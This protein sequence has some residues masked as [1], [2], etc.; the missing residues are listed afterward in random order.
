MHVHTLLRADFTAQ[1]PASAKDD[2]RMTL[3]SIPSLAVELPSGAMPATFD[4]AFA[5]DSP[6]LRWI[7]IN[8]RK[9]GARRPDGVWTPPIGRVRMR[10]RRRSSTLATARRPRWWA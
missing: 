5:V 4:G 2:A 7:P 10:T 6:T 8:D 1:L 9:L 3:I